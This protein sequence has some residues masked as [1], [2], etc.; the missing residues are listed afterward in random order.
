MSRHSF[1]TPA[2]QN[3]L[4]YVADCGRQIYCLDANTGKE[5][6]THPMKAHAWASPLVADGKVF[7]GSMRGDFHILAVGKEK[8]VLSTVDLGQ[9]G[10]TATAANGV[11]YVASLTRLYAIAK[12][13]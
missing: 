11:L 7:V 6:W 9:V 5:Y 1:S 8:K 4:V 2:I 13:P 10:A 12:A 3:D